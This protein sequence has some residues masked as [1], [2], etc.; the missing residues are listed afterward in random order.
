MA[1]PVNKIL[2]IG[3]SGQVGTE[4]ERSL[5]GQAE[6][7]CVDIDQL[8][9]CDEHSI[10]SN[11]KD[12]QPDVVINASAYTNVDGAEKDRGLAFQINATGPKTLAECCARQEALLIHYS[13]DF[14]FD[15]QKG[16]PYT[17]EDAPNPLNVYGESKLAGDQHIQNS[18][19]EYLI[20]RTS[21]V[22]GLRGKNFLLTMNRLARE[23]SA[24][25]IVDDQRG[26]PTW[27][28][29]IAE[30]TAAL[31]EKTKLN[32]G[33]NGN[34]RDL[35]NLS[36]EGDTTW[37]GFTKQMMEVFLQTEVKSLRLE[38]KPELIPIATSDYPLPARRPAYSVLS[39][40]KLL[41]KYGIQVPDWKQQLSSC[42]VV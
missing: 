8:N 33:G 34:L 32:N 39:K 24:L 29:A 21:W 28:R 7:T 23:R 40:E 13:T 12:I 1:K 19:C 9:L 5:K 30:G 35:V 2:I 11:L 27:C 16:S 41:K 17:E 20:L 26:S 37:F 6:L 14:V 22:Y 10:K 18:D 42:L 36:A 25:N 4:L 31:L 38:K 3:Q 15:G